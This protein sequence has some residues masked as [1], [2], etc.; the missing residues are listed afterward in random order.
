MLRVVRD[1]PTSE[2]RVAVLAVVLP[3]LLVLSVTG[4]AAAAD[5]TR[6]LIA[7]AGVH[8][9]ADLNPAGSQVYVVRADGTGLRRIT[10]AGP[11]EDTAPAWS[12]DGRRLAF[13]R[14]EGKGWR[15][16]VMNTNGSGLHAVTKPQPSAGS[17]SWS[18]DGT[19][20]VF[21]QLPSGLPSTGCYAQQLY[22]V[23]LDTGRVR[24]L[25]QFATFPG[26]ASSPAWSPDGERILFAGRRSRSEKGR[27]D[28]FVVAAD[29]S[30]LHRVIAR[31]TDPAWAGDGRMIAFIRA[32]D[33]YT[34][35]ASG[36]GVRR[37]TRTRDSES[38]PSWSPDGAWIAVARDHRPRDWKRETVRVYV[39]AADGGK[40]RAIT[41]ADAR[42]WADGPS[43]RP[44]PER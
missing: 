20:L 24:Q 16:Y 43:W 17:P 33:V 22:V 19:Q 36:T 42:F 11:W 28:L 38:R 37:R 23:S 8:W 26:G 3:L 6:G 12:P 27:T 25:T 2:I 44:A 10:N 9:T 30:G 29:G 14:R 4:G 40:M 35:S 5:S 21:V 1:R 34:A 7:F 39:V 31:A 18:P 41:P 13:G 32:G 15:L